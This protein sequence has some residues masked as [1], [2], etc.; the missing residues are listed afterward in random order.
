MEHQLDATVTV[1]WISK[2]SSTCFGQTFA[3]LRTYQH[4]C[5]IP[6]KSASANV[7]FY[8]NNSKNAKFWVVIL[9]ANERNVD[10]RMVY[11]GTETCRHARMLM[12]VY[13]VFWR[14]K[15]FDFIL[16]YGS[17]SFSLP[18]SAY[19]YCPTEWLTYGNRNCSDRFPKHVLYIVTNK[20]ERHQTQTP[21]NEAK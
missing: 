19:R 6:V 18:R 7:S 13:V 15:S 21:L 14:N 1:L 20:R 10:L 4:P 2:I 17:C 16:N 12:I 11:E 8:T 3:H 9:D 5:T